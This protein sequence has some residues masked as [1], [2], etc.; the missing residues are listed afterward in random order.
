[1]ALS[2]ASAKRG[3]GP[4]T[5]QATNAAIATT[6]TAGTNHADTTSASRWIGARVRWASPTIRTICAS[7]VSL[8]TRSARITKLPVPLMV[9]PVTRRP[10][11][12]TTGVGSPVSIDSSTV[13]R[14]STTMPSAGILLARPDAKAIAQADVG[15]RL[16]ELLSVAD[17]PGGLRRE[18]EQL[19][20]RGA[21]P[22]ASAE[23]ED[24]AEEHEDGDHDRRFE[25][26]LDGPV[27]TKPG[28]E[29]LRR[30]RRGHAE[31]PGRADT[32]G[33]EREHV[34]LTRPD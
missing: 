32:E 8:P 18:I 23:F 4:Q 10:A 1:M 7:T 30:E 28:R 25:V 3:S 13:L 2:N 9:A 21:R 15:H 20:N 31:Q 19:A 34:G 16:V 33:D 22:A 27:H 11:S 14:P 24:L 29:N 26:G 17:D 12:L 6:T 5:Y